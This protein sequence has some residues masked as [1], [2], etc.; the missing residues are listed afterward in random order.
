M[1]QEDINQ[2][3]VVT[4]ESLVGMLARDKILAFIQTRAELG[5]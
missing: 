2:L 5:I 3:P 4:D 1:T